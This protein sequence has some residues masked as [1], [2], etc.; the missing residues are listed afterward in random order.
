MKDGPEGASASNWT[1]SMQPYT[2]HWRMYT[3]IRRM[4]KPDSHRIIHNGA[5]TTFKAVAMRTARHGSGT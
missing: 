5:L 3:G 2:R 4:N 1:D